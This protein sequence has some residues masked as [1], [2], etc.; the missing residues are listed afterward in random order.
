[1]RQDNW[2]DH[3][4]SGFTLIELMITVAIVAILAAIAIPSYQDSV[5]KGKRGE[6]KAAILRTL[7]SEERYYTQNN[8]YLVFSS[9]TP[10]PTTTPFS[11]YSADNANNSRY[12]ISTEITTL[13]LTQGAL[14]TTSCSANDATKC[15]RVVATVANNGSD[16]SCGNKLY[17]DSTG[18]KQSAIYNAKCWN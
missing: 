5:W 8:T 14:T 18:V 4:F 3:R 6:A 16:P 12:T 1:M 7:Q 2:I 11:I 15:I 13:S 9:V 17:M 10:P